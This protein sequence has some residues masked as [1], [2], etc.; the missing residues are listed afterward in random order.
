VS[1]G[2]LPGVIIAMGL[3]MLQL[4]IKAS[5]PHDAL[6]GRLPNESDFHELESIPE[7]EPVPT[8]MIY[9]FEASL[10]FFN[11]DFFKSRV[12]G[13]LDEA[14]PRPLLSARRRDDSFTGHDRRCLSR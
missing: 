2:V 5:K 13:F 8:L 1:V 12:R 14:E 6:L 9:R 7:V 10:L 11:S 3:A 4:I